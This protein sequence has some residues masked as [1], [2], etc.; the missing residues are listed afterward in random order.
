MKK[1]KFTFFILILLFL[2]PIYDI[3][4]ENTNKIIKSEVYYI[5]INP[6]SNI[7]NISMIT[8]LK[9][10]NQKLLS[11]KKINSIS[12]FESVYGNAVIS[13]SSN[14]LNVTINKKDYVFLRSKLPPNFPLPINLQFKYYF[15]D[16]E[17]SNPKTILNR[18]G[19]FKIVFNITNNSKYTANISYKTL[20]NNKTVT[21]QEEIYMPYVALIQSD[22]IPIIDYDDITVTS[23]VKMI[24]GESYSVN[25]FIFPFPEGKAEITFEGVIKKIPSFKISVSPF[26]YNLPDIVNK[27]IED[28]NN[29]ITSTFIN[30]LEVKKNLLQIINFEQQ[31]LDNIELFNKEFKALTPQLLEI[32]DLFNFYVG[33]LERVI[34]INNLF[35][36]IMYKLK[37]TI[38][39]DD[40]TLNEINKLFEVNNYFIKSVLEGLE[41]DGKS[42]PG[43]YDF[44]EI[45]TEG[46]KSSQL[47]TDILKQFKEGTLSIKNALSDSNDIISKYEVEVIKIINE[48][49]KDTAKFNKIFTLSKDLLDYSLEIE[50]IDTEKISIEKSVQFIYNLVF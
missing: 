33:N 22:S 10:L 43:M 40:K 36:Q 48:L 13:S 31:I 11:L 15:N 34:K 8:I 26:T 18:K 6:N 7:K 2:F 39:L 1:K 44:P 50:N 5:N 38:G 21:S 3:T 42:I 4:A 37:D 28:T 9:W 30:Y 45:L 23:G 35:V 32:Q 27:T 46:E 17:I 41:V 49:R 20:P 19:K 47:I 24:V 14:N 16:K 25:M 12:N 29:K